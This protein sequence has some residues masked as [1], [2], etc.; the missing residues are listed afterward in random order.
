MNF[1]TYL[2]RKS[3]A[4]ALDADELKMPFSECTAVG[5]A[6]RQAAERPAIARI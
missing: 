6:G 2:Y 5:V 4:T 1:F 3:A